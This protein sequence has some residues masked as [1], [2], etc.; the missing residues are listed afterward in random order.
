MTTTKIGNVIWFT[1]PQAP[2]SRNFLDLP[3][4]NWETIVLF[5]AVE[6]VNED[7]NQQN[8]EPLQIETISNLDL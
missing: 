3:D 5:P 2:L 1:T 6:T 7:E 4:A 8:S